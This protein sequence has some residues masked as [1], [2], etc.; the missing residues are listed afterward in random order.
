MKL[1][2][3]NG[4][5]KTQLVNIVDFYWV[6]T[7]LVLWYFW[8]EFWPDLISKAA[9]FAYWVI[10]LKREIITPVYFQVAL[11]KMNVNADHINLAIGANN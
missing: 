2:L 6:E 4:G 10:Q 8:S 11:H 5:I 1:C 7:K 9:G 3:A